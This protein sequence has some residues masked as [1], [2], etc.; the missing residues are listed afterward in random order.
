MNALS[1]F[2]LTLVSVTI[3]YISP[4]STLSV[5][6]SSAIDECGATCTTVCYDQVGSVDPYDCTRIVIDFLA[7]NREHYWLMI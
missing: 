3:F 2:I 1:L 7:P 4:G 6:R 5:P